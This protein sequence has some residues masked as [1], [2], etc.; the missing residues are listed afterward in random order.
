[1]HPFRHTDYV[2]WAHILYIF[3]LRLSCMISL[4][5]LEWHK[6][7]TKS[8]RFNFCKF[9][10]SFGK[11]MCIVRVVG[12]EILLAQQTYLWRWSVAHF[13]SSGIVCG[14]WRIWFFNFWWIC[15]KLLR[16]L[17]AGW[18][19]QTIQRRRTQWC[20]E[21]W[22]RGMARTMWLDRMCATEMHNVQ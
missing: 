11:R 17:W 20:C 21:K 19:A 4:Q 9:F 8:K 18:M 6:G 10:F 5:W 22:T 7:P 14:M 2:E 13:F 12:R 16:F 1:M 3:S 15:H